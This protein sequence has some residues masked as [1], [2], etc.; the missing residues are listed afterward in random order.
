MSKTRAGLC[1]GLAWSDPRMVRSDTF[2][3]RIS[4]TMNNSL[5]SLKGRSA[6]ITGG[7][8]GIGE[9][10]ARSFSDAG[11]DV[12][13]SSRTTSELEST[14]SRLVDVSGGKV[15]WHQADMSNRDDVDNL[16]RFAID[17]LGKVDILVNNA[18]TNIPEEL[19]E[20][21]DV[22]WDRIIELNLTSCVRLARSLSV[23]MAKRGWGRIIYIASIMGSV[24]ARGRSAYCGSKAALIGMSHAQALELGESGVTVNCISPGPIL[25]DLPRQ[26]LSQKEKDRFTAATALARWGEPS[27]I[28]GPALL[29]AS[30]AGSYITG[31]NITVD[32]GVTI[33]GF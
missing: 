6:L 27:E 17:K 16:G 15:F 13:I 7:S 14:A 11:A 28:A 25:T 10:I 20:L 29:L 2:F 26:A 33:K 12:L 30:D 4:N 1:D 31:S 24:G 19:S 22:S 9:A 18:G 21:D 5:F 8:K 23:P 32:G 3:R